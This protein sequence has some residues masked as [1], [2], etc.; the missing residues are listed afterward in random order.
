MNKA[1]Y[2][3]HIRQLAEQHGIAMEGHSSGGRAF[4]KT[5]TIKT[6]PVKS[7]ITYALALHEIGHIVGPWQ[8]QARLFKEAGAWKWAM[9]NAAVWTAVMHSYMVKSLT[10]YLNWAE[11]KRNRGVRNAPIIPPEGHEFWDLLVP[12]EE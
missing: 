5:R 7:A 6:K 9:D 3:N 11:R 8:S 1:E 12:E 10:S 2:A 4:R